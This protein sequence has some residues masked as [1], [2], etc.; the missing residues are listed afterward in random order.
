MTKLILFNLIVLTGLGQTLKIAPNWTGVS[1]DIAGYPTINCA[2]CNYEDG[3]NPFIQRTIEGT[4]QF[5]ISSSTY[6]KCSDE[7]NKIL[8]KAS[9]NFSQVLLKESAVSNKS[10]YTILKI[11][12]FRR[13][14]QG[15]YEKLDSITIQ[16]QKSL[17]YILC[18]LSQ[19]VRTTHH[20]PAS[21]C[22]LASNTNT[23]I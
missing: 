7:E 5:S 9:L 2:N 12:P 11:N 6:S 3:K 4:S 13:N 8:E 21:T 20:Q 17:V 14:I 19:I 16:I 10:N 1:S 18:F 23:T 15:G 22:V